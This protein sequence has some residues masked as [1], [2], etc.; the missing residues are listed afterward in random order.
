MLDG[1]S[2][3]TPVVD[4]DG[5]H[6]AVEAATLRFGEHDDESSRFEVAFTR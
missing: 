1:R 2:G 3:P 4:H 5:D 6:Q